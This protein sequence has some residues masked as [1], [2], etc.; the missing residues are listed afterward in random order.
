MVHIFCQNG[1]KL[2]LDSESGAVHIL[3]DIAYSILEKFPDGLPE[4]FDGVP[5]FDG[6]SR[7][8]VKEELD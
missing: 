2:A 1:Y 8:D 5:E 6:F 4:S 7:E 3:S